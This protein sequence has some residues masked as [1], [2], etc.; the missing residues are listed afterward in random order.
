MKILNTIGIGFADEAKKMLESQG[1]V[2][3]TTP[4]QEELEKIVKDFD[5]LIVGLGLNIN[6]AVIDAGPKLKIIA[7]ATTGLD[8]I[9][10]AYAKEKGIEIISLKDDLEFMK[11]ITGTAELA[12]GLLL[13]LVRKIPSAF[14]AVKIGQ[15]RR[16]DFKG[17]SLS[18]KTL[19]IIGM[20]RLGS[21]VAQYG[22]VF[23]MN[24]VFTDP[25]VESYEGVKKVSLPE[26]LS[27]SD[28]MSLHVHL[29]K[30]TE[31][32]IGEKEFELMKK[33]AVLINTARGK[34]VDEAALLQA[35]KK[36]RIAGYATDVLSDELDFG[37]K[38]PEN[39]LLVKYAKENNNLIIVPHIGGMTHESRILTDVR[40][41]EKLKEFWQNLS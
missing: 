9:D 5:I 10:V 1:E 25:H 6:K 32:L 28:V 40:I 3:Y 30:E 33:S 14:E 29:S 4:S 24:V 15:W 8:H 20:G 12:W 22:R 27:Q 35:L 37:E 7:T 36:G 31:N 39:H 21:L 19:G 2:T 38:I 34:I 23:G 18:E 16:D 11:R 17:N 26:L 41:A 13:S